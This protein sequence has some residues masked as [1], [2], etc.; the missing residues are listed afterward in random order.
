MS[1]PK[2]PFFEL[3]ED[4]Q[5]KLSSIAPDE[6]PKDW[7]RAIYSARTARFLAENERIW[8]TGRIFLPLSLACVAIWATF[9]P[10]KLIPVLALAIL[11]IGMCYL[12]HR[13]S[14]THKRYQEEHMA[15]L[16]AIEKHVGLHTSLR[17]PDEKPSIPQIRKIL[18]VLLSIAW[19][20]ITLTT[21]CTNAW[22]F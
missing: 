3:V 5:S 9:K 18:L 15:W 1:Q 21:G 17:L 11:S 6:D 12:W 7:Y 19:G 2:T 8:T 14:T 20:L 13:I 4:I 10:T 22:Q 16:V